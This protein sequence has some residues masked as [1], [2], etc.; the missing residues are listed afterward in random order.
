MQLVVA[1][2]KARTRG[3]KDCRSG[4]QQR[5]QGKSIG[6]N[7]VLKVVAVHDSLS[8]REGFHHVHGPRPSARC[9]QREQCYP[10]RVECPSFSRRFLLHLIT[11][12]EYSCRSRV[13]IV[14]IPVTAPRPIR[15]LAERVKLTGVPPRYPRWHPLRRTI[16][17]QRPSV[18]RRANIATCLFCR[19]RL[20][21]SAN[22]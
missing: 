3:E 11:I 12:S 16:E 19:F 2:R 7:D 6:S 22:L 5:R 21:F 17:A 15:V 13:S 9:Q 14:W 10:D 1:P 8:G 20:R 18:D 4:V